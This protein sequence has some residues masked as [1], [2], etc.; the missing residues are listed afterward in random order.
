MA[1]T[2]FI[3]PRKNPNNEKFWD[4]LVDHCRKIGRNDIAS[5]KRERDYFR[6]EIGNPNYDIF[7]QIANEE[8]RIGLG[9]IPKDYLDNILTPKKST[10]T[11]KYGS[12]LAWDAGKK[13]SKTRRIQDAIEAKDFNSNL[14]SWRNHI[15]WLIAQFDK[16]RRAV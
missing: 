9:R 4:Q 3:E 6:I 1:A 2:P 11:T 8:I 13:N 5:G 14:A 15:D 7:F 10:I 12:G 16:L